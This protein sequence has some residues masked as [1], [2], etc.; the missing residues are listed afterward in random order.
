MGRGRQSLWVMRRYV[1]GAPLERCPALWLLVVGVGQLVLGGWSVV[2]GTACCGPSRGETCRSVACA[3]E[4]GR[5]VSLFWICC[6]AEG[7]QFLAVAMGRHGQRRWYMILVGGPHGSYWHGLGR[8]M[9]ASCTLSQT[10]VNK[11]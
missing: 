9:V 1:V 4:H 11:P 10:G 3:G 7:R 5:P 6:L 2:G 8:R